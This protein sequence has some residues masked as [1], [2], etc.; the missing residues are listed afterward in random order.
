MWIMSSG[1][2]SAPLMT[3]WDTVTHT[4]EGRVK[5]ERGDE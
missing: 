2:I 5:E 4:Y 3:E 1:A